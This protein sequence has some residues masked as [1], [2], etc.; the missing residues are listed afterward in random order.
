MCNTGSGFQTLFHWARFVRKGSSCIRGNIFL[1]INDDSAVTI[2]EQ[3]HTIKAKVRRRFSN[4][5]TFL[6]SLHEKFLLEN[7]NWRKAPS[8]EM[9]RLTIHVNNAYKPS[10]N[11]E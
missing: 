2:I 7:W 10:K 3:R 9:D 11:Q 5:W 6:V 1:H 4:K 8:K